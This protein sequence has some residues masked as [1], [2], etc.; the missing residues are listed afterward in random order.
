MLTSLLPS[1]PLIL[2]NVCM[3]DQA[4]VARR[5]CSCPLD[6]IGW[7]T[8][9]SEVR[10]FEKLTAGGLTF[11]DFDVIRVLEEVLPARFGGSGLDFQLLERADRLNGQGQIQLLVNPAL[12][13]LDAGEVIDVFLAALGGGSG[14]ERLMELQWRTN[15]VV[16]VVREP[17]RKTASGKILHLDLQRGDA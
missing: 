13:E 11:L 6:G 17:A 9:L 3:G 14:G 10:S 12:G 4:R 2:L 15:Q 16:E 1:A 7:H 5:Q 8:H